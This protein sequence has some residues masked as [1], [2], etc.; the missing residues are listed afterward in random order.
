MASQW[1]YGAREARQGPFSDQQLRTLADQ[2]LI[3]P[4][5]TI[6]KEGVEQGVPAHRVKNLL[7]AA[8]APA[9]TP[10]APESPPPTE[11]PPPPPSSEVSPQAPEPEPRE[12]TD[13]PPA[14]G[15]VAVVPADS[16]NGTEPD[17]PDAEAAE[18][19]PPEQPA[20]APKPQ[21]PPPGRAR[22]AKAVALKGCI[23]VSQDGETVIFTKKCI[24][25]GNTE[26]GRSRLPVRMGVTRTTY[27]CR[28]CKKVRPIEIQ[29][30]P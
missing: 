20:E 4:T 23:I 16:A 8:T 10:V 26:T 29:G 6:W 1:Y 13:A 25:C 9:S 27:F 18:A 12:A 2:G 5:D 19:K 24:V 3:Q 11:P 7:P 28:K 14:E 17:A 21:P 30:M 22:K 15:E